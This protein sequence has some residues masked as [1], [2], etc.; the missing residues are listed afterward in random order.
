MFSICISIRSARILSHL[1]TKPLQRVSKVHN[2]HSNVYLSSDKCRD[3]GPVKVT[4]NGYFQ[5]RFWKPGK[6]RAIFGL[7]IGI[8]KILFSVFNSKVLVTY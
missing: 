7:E 6:S 5:V 2:C 4:R 8:F 3:K 1:D